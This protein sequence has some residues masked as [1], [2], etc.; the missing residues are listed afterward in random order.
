MSHIHWVWME[1][2]WFR[3]LFFRISLHGCLLD[4]WASKSWH[5]RSKRAWYCFCGKPMCSKSLRML[6]WSLNEECLA[7][8]IHLR[9]WLVCYHCLSLLDILRAGRRLLTNLLG[10]CFSSCLAVEGKDRSAWADFSSCSFPLSHQQVI[11]QHVGMW[12]FLSK[13]HLLER[14]YLYGDDHR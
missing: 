6:W 4:C 3:M 7:K 12:F 5:Y 2:A 8:A 11:N 10:T 9:I 14:F 13:L 1:P